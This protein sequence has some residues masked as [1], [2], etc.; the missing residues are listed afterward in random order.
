IDR[1]FND[2]CKLCSFS[3]VMEVAESK[4]LFN[5]IAFFGDFFIMVF[6]T[7][8]AC[9]GEKGGAIIPPLWN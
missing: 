9:G 4:V 2:S 8:P 5:D 3:S 7:P 1:I 6:N